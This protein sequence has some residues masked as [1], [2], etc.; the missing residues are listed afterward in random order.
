MSKKQSDSKTRDEK[1]SLPIPSLLQ[2]LVECRSERQQQ[3]LFERLRQ[4]GYACR[5]LT[6]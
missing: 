4:E 5:V 6:L 3:E 1:P 2:I